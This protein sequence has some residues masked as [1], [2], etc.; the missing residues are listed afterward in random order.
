MRSLSETGTSTSTN[1]NTSK[2]ARSIPEMTGAPQTAG[3]RLF[4]PQFN[5]DSPVTPK[6]GR[7]R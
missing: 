3:E 1:T 7:D 2:T 4:R 6:N 5:K